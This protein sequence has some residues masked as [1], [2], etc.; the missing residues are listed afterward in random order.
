[1]YG[2]VTITLEKGAADLLTI[3]SSCLVSKTDKGEGT[4]YVVRDGKAHLVPVRVGMD[5]GV[6]TEV[7]KGLK[8]GAEVINNPPS[9]IEDGVPVTVAVVQGTPV[10]P[11]PAT[12]SNN[13]NGTRM[14]AD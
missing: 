6:D 3:P 4:V 1:M 14:N 8:P 7:L 10:T 2:R 9:G 12:D 11:P 5:N 13:K